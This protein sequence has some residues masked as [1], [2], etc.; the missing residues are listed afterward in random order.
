MER[1]SLSFSERMAGKVGSRNLSVDLVVKIPDLYKFF[2]NP[3]HEGEVTGTINLDGKTFSIDEG[4]GTFSLFS[5]DKTDHRLKHLK[6]FLSFRMNG[7]PYHLDG[8][9]A[10]KDDEGADAIKDIT[11]LY[12]TLSP[13]PK[14]GAVD[15][16][17]VIYFDSKDFLDLFRSIVVEGSNKLVQIGAKATFI[18]FCFGQMFSTYIVG[19]LTELLEEPKTTTGR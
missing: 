7:I 6:Y 10:I 8:R 2:Q 1:L 5:P 3:E 16:E 14:S 9:K 4:Q 12:V 19:K 18:G 13:I 11:T 15:E 17:G